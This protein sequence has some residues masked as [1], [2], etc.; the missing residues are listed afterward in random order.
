MFVWLSIN[1]TEL[2][3]IENNIERKAETVH[4]QFG[5]LETQRCRNIF[6]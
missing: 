3:T 1:L 2:D 4:Q 6:A 5:T